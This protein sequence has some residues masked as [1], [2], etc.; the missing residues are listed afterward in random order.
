[1]NKEVSTIN[2]EKF[3]EEIIKY[4]LTSDNIIDFFIEEDKNMFKY[5]L[6]TYI[7]M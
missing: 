3:S 6:K 5:M 2:F 1:M 7:I 4:N